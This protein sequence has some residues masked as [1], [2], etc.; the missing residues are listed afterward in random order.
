M[1]TRVPENTHKHGFTLIEVIIA[2]MLA[3]LMGTIL[4]QYTATNLGAT[5]ESLLAVENN[6]RAVRLMES[7][8]RDYRNWLENH[9]DA[10]IADFRAIVENDPDYAPVQTEI[11]SPGVLRADDPADSILLVTVEAGERKLTSLFTK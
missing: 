1:K 11:V 8:T 3:A 6:S 5:A 10:T 2:L 7:I 9:P 4:V